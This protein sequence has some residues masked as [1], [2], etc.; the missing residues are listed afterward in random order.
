MNTS[1]A[2]MKAVSL[3]KMVQSLSPLQADVIKTIAL[4][5]M[6]ADHVNIILLGGRSEFLYAFGHAAFPLFTLLWAINLPSD[7]TGLRERTRRLWV[8]AFATQPLFWLAFMMNGQ[9]WM[10]LNILFAYAGCTQL[11]YWAKRW[12]IN[13][14]MAGISL[15]L[16][17]AWPLTPA[18]Y[19][20]AGILF[21]LMCLAGR[22]L[23]GAADNGA[24]L[25][26]VFIAM[27]CLNMPPVIGGWWADA[28]TFDFI[29]TLVIPLLV[30]CAVSALP[31]IPARRIWPRRFFYHAYAAH[32]TL[33]AVLAVLPGKF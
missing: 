13:G 19:G 5:A 9:S 3:F 21:C 6:L 16:T 1:F 22:Y 31:V 30:I 33:L 25:F 4:A 29:P 26:A 20:V 24:F 28:L 2:T 32:L 8:W 12:G 15:L 7:L 23:S 17:V 18:S 27:G 10:A 11:V 14:A